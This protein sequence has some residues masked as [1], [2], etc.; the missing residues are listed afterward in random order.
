[1]LEAKLAKLEPGPDQARVHMS[2][3]YHPGFADYF[4]LILNKCEYSC[5]LKL[6]DHRIANSC[7]GPWL[8]LLYGTRGQS[9]PGLASI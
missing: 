3:I 8:E 5:I 2:C 9:E 1:V 7:L 6:S 4:S